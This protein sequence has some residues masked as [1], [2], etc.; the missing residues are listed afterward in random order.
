LKI[1]VLVKE[2]PDAAVDKTIGSD[3]RID[4]SGEK[5]LNPSDT[6]ALE[7]AVQLKEAG[8]DVSEI[9]AV[10]VGPD[11]AARTL[12]GAVSRGADRSIHL[13][14]A[15]LAG[16]DVVA[17]GYALAELIKRESPELVLLGQQSEDGGSYAVG[18]VVGAFLEQPALSQVSKLDLAGDTLTVERQAE[19]GYDTLTVTLP[20]VI[21]VSDSANEPRYPSLKAIM[22]AKKKPVEKL[23]LAGA[24]IDAGKVGSAGS[25]VEC[26]DFQA[27]ASKPAGTIITDEDTAATVEQIIAWLDSRKLV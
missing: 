19:Y 1:L 2:V 26:K 4:R 20:A 11:S 14:D 21:S 5:T 27:P 24:G 10:T 15:G 22:G 25:A 16:S 7:A 9:V 23:D 18:A 13:S 8:A 12:Q 3:G 6:N 17:T